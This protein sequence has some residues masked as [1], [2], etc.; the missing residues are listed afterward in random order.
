MYK[1][2]RHGSTEWNGSVKAE[3]HTHNQQVAGLTDQNSTF[4]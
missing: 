4:M 2:S 3:F 1:L